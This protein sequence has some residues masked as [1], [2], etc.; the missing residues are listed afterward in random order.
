MTSP[1]PGMDPYIED[2]GLWPDFHSKLIGEIEPRRA[3]L[4]LNK[5][6]MIDLDVPRTETNSGESG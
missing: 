4:R 3:L 5:G 1:F 2:H 6:V